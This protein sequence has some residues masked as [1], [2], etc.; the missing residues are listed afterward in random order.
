MSWGRACA[1]FA[2]GLVVLV[3][4]VAGGFR[5]AAAWREVATVDTIAP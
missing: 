4:L 3:T 2:I 5:L 1:V